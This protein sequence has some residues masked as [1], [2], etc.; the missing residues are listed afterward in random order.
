MNFLIFRDFSGIY[1]SFFIIFLHVG[2]Y[3]YFSYAGDV[4]QRE[5]LDAQSNKDF[6]SSLTRE[7]I[8]VI[9]HSSLF[10]LFAT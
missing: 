2:L 9:S 8:M 1:P 7:G 6:Q 10:S 5:V 4:A 3:L